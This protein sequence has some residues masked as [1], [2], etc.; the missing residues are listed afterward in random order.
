MAATCHYVASGLAQ[1]TL[2][3]WPSTQ[4]M[5]TYSDFSMSGN[6]S[7]RLQQHIQT[8]RLFYV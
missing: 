2:V 4:E 5:A 8:P 1:R 3:S 6:L 7:E